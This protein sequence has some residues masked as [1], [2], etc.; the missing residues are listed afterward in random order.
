MKIN[1]YTGKEVCERCG[2]AIKNIYIITFSDGFTI[3]CGSECVKKVMKET[4]LNAMGMKYF[5]KQMKRI[6]DFEKQI[7]EWKAKTYESVVETDTVPMKEVECMKYRPMTKEEF[8]EYK[9]FRLEELYPY[10]IKQIQDE[11]EKKL[12][13]VKHK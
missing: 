4:N 2:A 8:E 13:G 12:K 6:H 5:N 10:Q 11:M 9:K 7:E 1:F 3:K